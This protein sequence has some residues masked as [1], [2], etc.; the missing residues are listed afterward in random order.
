[1][2]TGWGLAPL[3]RADVELLNEP[4]MEEAQDALN[5]CLLLLHALFSRY[6]GGRQDP[7]FEEEPTLRQLHESLVPLRDVHPFWLR[8]AQNVD[9]YWRLRRMVEKDGQTPFLQN[10]AQQATDE[11][12]DQW[13]LLTLYPSMVRDTEALVQPETRESILARP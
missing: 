13:S 4:G 10:A 2:R 3:T 8:M 1:M 11:M 5:E 6:T 7:R 12:L 9:A